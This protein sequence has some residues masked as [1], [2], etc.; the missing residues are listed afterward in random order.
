[1]SNIGTMVVD[2]AAVT[3]ETIAAPSAGAAIVTTTNPDGRPEASARY[4]AHAAAIFAPQTISPTERSPRG[5]HATLKN[6]NACADQVDGGD[7]SAREAG[8]SGVAT[9][10]KGA[11][12]AFA[13][14]DATPSTVCGI[15]MAGHCVA[16]DADMSWSDAHELR[17]NMEHNSEMNETNTASGDGRAASGNKSDCDDVEGMEPPPENV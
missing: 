6:G 11:L 17:A 5:G 4:R 14:E 12:S 13:P 3:T 16:L 7:H 15:G 9:T 1:M 10:R 8:A 2:R